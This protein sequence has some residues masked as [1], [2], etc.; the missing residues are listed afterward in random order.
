MNFTYWF[1]VKM[2]A[3]GYKHVGTDKSGL[4][5]VLKYTA[6]ARNGI[7]VS[8][9]VA[10]VQM[11]TTEEYIR[12]VFDTIPAPVLFIVDEKVVRHVTTGNAPLWLRALHAIYY[13]RVYVW[14]EGNSKQ[15]SMFATHFDWNSNRVMH[16][17]E[18]EVDGI[19]FDQTQSKLRDFPGTFKIAR[20][21]DRAFWKDDA[22]APPKRDTPKY[23]TWEEY[24]RKAYNSTDWTKQSHSNPNY[25]QKQSDFPNQDDINE[26][27]KRAFREHM[28]NYGYDYAPPKSSPRQQPTG[29]KW[30]QGFMSTGSLASAK[31]LFKQLAKEWHPDLNPGK[32]E[33]LETMK[34]INIAFEKAEEILR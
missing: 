32:P 17:D 8:F 25:S 9:Y 1:T 6:E 4:I 10:Y 14:T 22:K 7:Y 2:Q 23:E 5:D 33:A 12:R 15:G 21:Y 13:G 11:N 19:L 31:T 29:D 28:R 26:V 30:L 27:F 20:F 3:I 34:A 18:I 24:T 16:S